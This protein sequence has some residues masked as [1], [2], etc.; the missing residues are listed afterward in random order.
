[1]RLKTPR[2]PEPEAPRWQVLAMTVVWLGGSVLPGG[3]LGRQRG[4]AGGRVMAPQVVPGSAH[5]RSGGGG[6]D[7]P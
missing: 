2:A 7:G 3:R 5:C 6:V 1:M 4:C